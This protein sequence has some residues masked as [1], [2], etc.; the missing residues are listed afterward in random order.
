MSP[1][2]PSSV[3]IMHA[4]YQKEQFSLAYVHAVTTV[5]GYTLEHVQVDIDSVDAIIC[6]TDRTGNVHSPR[7]EVQVKCTHV[8]IATETELPFQLKM[9]NYDDLRDPNV[10]VPT[11]LVVVFTP[12]DLDGWLEHSEEQL[13]LRRCGYWVSL[14]GLPEVISSARNPRPTVKLPR[15]Q[16][17]N[18]EQVRGVMGRIAAG[19]LP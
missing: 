3:E 13:V 19:G 7:C 2:P 9:K 5:A 8:N 6:S 12:R 11:I 14:R 17:F 4:A 18:V 15:R 16:R 1:P 10:L